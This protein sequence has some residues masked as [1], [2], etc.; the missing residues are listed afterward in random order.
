MITRQEFEDLAAKHGLN[1]RSYDD[2]AEACKWD[3][4]LTIGQ[5]VFD[6]SG[7]EGRANPACHKLDGWP[8]CQCNSCGCTEPATTTDDSSVPVCEACA[9]YTVDANGDT[10]CSRQTA[11]FRT[12]HVCGRE[13]DWG[14]IST[15]GRPGTPNHR[16]GTCGCGDAWLDEDRGGWGHYSYHPQDG[17]S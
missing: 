15:A 12:C 2:F 6:E 7:Y 13:I 9:E 11:D 17:M 3:E 16:V 5:W 14:G 4:D 8:D 10:V 1:V